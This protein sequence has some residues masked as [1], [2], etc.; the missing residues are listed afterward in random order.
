M[1]Q[2]YIDTINKEMIAVMVTY[3]GR[4]SY[5]IEMFY[6]TIFP[7]LFVVDT[8]TETFIYEPLYGQQITQQAL[9]QYFQP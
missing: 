4:S 1:N 5:P 8:K 2:P 6:T 3:E 9:H 7:A